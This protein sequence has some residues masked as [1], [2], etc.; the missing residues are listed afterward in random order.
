MNLPG[1]YQRLA[2]RHQAQG[3]GGIAVVFRSRPLYTV[4]QLGDVAGAG[5]ERAQHR[6]QWLRHTPAW[7]AS[8]T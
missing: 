4:P 5:E 1:P 7:H 3:D 8:V 6:G 2:V